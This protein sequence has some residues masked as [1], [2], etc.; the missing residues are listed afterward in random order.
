MKVAIATVG[1]VLFVGAAAGAFMTGQRLWGAPEST[2][3]VSLDDHAV[4]VRFSGAGAERY[5]EEIV[6]S[7]DGLQW[8]RRGLATARDRRPICRMTDGKLVA[9]VLDGGG[10]ILGRHMC[11]E[12]AGDGWRELR[13]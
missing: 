10:A 1:L 6:R 8:W 13:N 2:C 5:C 9:D 4:A 12:M 3:F 11:G 7:S